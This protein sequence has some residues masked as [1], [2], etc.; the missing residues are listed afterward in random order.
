MKGKRE[1]VKEKGFTKDRMALYWHVLWGLNEL[2]AWPVSG[3]PVVNTTV[4]V[5]D[6]V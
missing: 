5:S 4:T 3:L 1:R 6:P 2:L